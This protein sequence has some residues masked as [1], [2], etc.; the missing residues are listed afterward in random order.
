MMVKMMYF[1]ELFKVF[2]PIVIFLFTLAVA[3]ILRRIIFVKLSVWSKRT[4]SNVGDII[5]SSLKNPFIIWFIFLGTYFALKASFLPLHF[6]P[7]IEKI[8]LIAVVFSVSLFLSN[9]IV[10]LIKLYAGK[11]EGSLP[12]TSLTQN[13][14]RLII[15]GLGILIILNSLGI[16]ITPILATLGVGGL[17]VALALQDTLANFFAGFYIIVS[18]Q[19]KPGDYIKLEN[20]EEGYVVDISWRITRIRTLANNMVLVPN[21]KLLKT[22]IVNYYQPDKELAVLINLGVHYNSDLEKVERIVLEVADEVM[23]DL[24]G[25][26]KNFKPSLRYHTFGDYSIQFTVILRAKEFTDQYLIKHEFI[27]KLHKRFKEEG[28]IIPYPV[29]A[30]NFFQEKK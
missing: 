6:Y 16:S 23:K 1:W 25:G 28:I 11:I 30:I 17:A 2:S 22:V 4:K 12:I 20:A 19:I 5:I 13:L 8:F 27:K 15:F 3:Y 9:L 14:S 26:M 29:R 21:E 18:R 7:Y 10:K 24:V